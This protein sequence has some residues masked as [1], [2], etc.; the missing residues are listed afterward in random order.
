M[1]RNWTATHILIAINGAVYLLWNLLQPQAAGADPFAL[2]L[3]GHP[4]FGIWQYLTS[5]FMHA[6][7]GHLIMNMFGLF[8]FGSVLERMWGKRRF[9][10]FFLLTGLGAG[11][12]FSAVTRYEVHTE[13][14]HLVEEGFSREALREGIRNPNPRAGL[15]TMMQG[16]SDRITE[17]TGDQLANLYFTFNIPVVGASGAIYGILTAFG[18]LFPDAKLALIFLPLPV[19]AKIFIPLLLL[20]DLFSGVTGFSLFGGGIAHFAHLG[21]ALIGLLLMRHWR[22]L[23]APVQPWRFS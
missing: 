13:T 20:A 12:I 17:E 18:L 22:D 9:A 23:S 6:S 5:M 8:M 16:N 21:G 7:A 2:Y 19:P 1:P 3:P 15:I 14:Q 4:S 11:L 10:L